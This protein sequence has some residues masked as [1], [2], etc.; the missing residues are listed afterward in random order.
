[1]GELIS[2]ELFVVENQNSGGTGMYSGLSQKIGLWQV[3]RGLSLK[4]HQI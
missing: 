1:M 4:N 3:E 2:S